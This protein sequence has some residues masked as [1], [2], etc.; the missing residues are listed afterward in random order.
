MISFARFKIILFTWALFSVDGAYAEKKESKLDSSIN[1]QRDIIYSTVNNVEVKLDIYRPKTEPAILLPAIIGIHGG[2]WGS[3]DKADYAKW[4][5]LFSQHGYVTV[6]IN[7]RLKHVAP[8]PAA[9]E[10]C[11][12][13]IRWLR[14]NAEKYGI[15]PNRL[16]A[17]GA[18][19][20]GHLA[21]M[22]GYVDK[23]SGLEGKGNEIFSSNVKAVCSIAGITDLTEW[24]KVSDGPLEFIGGKPDEK[25]HE[26]KL[27]SPMTHVTK[28]APST[29]LIHSEDDHSVPIAHSEILFNRLQELGVTSSFLRVKNAKHPLNV[30]EGK[31]IEP[32]REVI[33]Q[34]IIEFFDRYLK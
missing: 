8:F 21:L 11:K 24:A 22:V 20:G 6:S 25:P 19:A 14:A 18:S 4:A 30:I 7:Y 10:D 5:P 12:T 17:M 28:G 2:G 3:G 32:S 29:F 23:A 9:V 1:T 13:A 26:Y 34:K 15:D 16:G 27:A 31:L 33:N